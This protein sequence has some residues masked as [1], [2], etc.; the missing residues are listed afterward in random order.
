MKDIKLP[1]SLFDFFAVLFPGVI[2]LFTIYLWFNPALSARNSVFQGT[3]FEKFGN[4]LLIATFVVLAAY[5]VGYLINAVS[6]YLIDRPANALLG[7]PVHQFLVKQGLMARARAKRPSERKSILTRFQF[8]PVPANLVR[9]PF[10]ARLEAVL[11][12]DVGWPIDANSAFKICYYIV[13]KEN[14][15]AD[16]LAQTFIAM[17]TMFQGI[18][19]AGILLMAVAFRNE[20]AHQETTQ[21]F[22]LV[23]GVTLFV[24]ALVMYRRYKRLWAETVFYSYAATRAPLA[25]GADEGANQ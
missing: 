11:K 23:A 1:F 16:A 4:E 14:P 20:L 24:C 21:T 18:S 8:D 3:I 13:Q 7:W 15:A 2:M 25:D 22:W 9:Y 5:L 17:A 12:K 6:E 19:L 10:G